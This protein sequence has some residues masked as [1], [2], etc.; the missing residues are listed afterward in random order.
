MG[1]LTQSICGQGNLTVDLL[2]GIWRVFCLFISM[3]NQCKWFE[4]P[5]ATKNTAYHFMQLLRG[6]FLV[7]S[8]WNS[9]P[10]KS[11]SA[12]SQAKCYIKYARKIELWSMENLKLYTLANFFIIK[13][14]GKLLQTA[15]LKGLVIIYHLCGEG[16]ETS[17]KGFADGRLCWSHNIIYL[18]PL[19]AALY[20]FLWSPPFRSHLQFT[21]IQFLQSSSLILCWRRLILLRA[22]LRNLVIFQNSSRT[23]P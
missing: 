7:C 21:D 18:T 16:A 14:I 22:P 17:V 2:R 19:H 4:R 8:M 15:T 23:G 20:I 1:V 10:W 9:S 3:S 11:L 6:K 13:T 12:L 5:F